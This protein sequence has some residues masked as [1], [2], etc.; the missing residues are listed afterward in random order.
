MSDENGIGNQAPVA[1]TTLDNEAISKPSTTSKPYDDDMLEAYAKE[2]E[3]ESTNGEGKTDGESESVKDAKGGQEE[4][5]K[6]K[7][8]AALSKKGDKVDDGFEKV[9]VKRV[10]NGKEV[11]FTVE[12]AIKSHVKQEDFNRN[13]DK[14]LSQADARDRKWATDQQNFKGKI[15]KLIDVAQRGDFVT[16]IRGIAKLAAGG[17]GL[18]VVKFEEKYFSQLDKVRDVLTK[19]TPA[20]QKTY[21]AERR[22]AEMEADNKALREEKEA[23]V[24]TSQLESRVIS[25][26]KHYQVPEQEF[27][28][29]YETLVKEEVGE[30]KFFKHPDDITPEEVVR[31][32]L[33]VRHEEK[34]LTA[35][36][37][38]GIE[39]D[40]ILTKIS[41]VAKTEDN[42]SVE[43]IKELIRKSGIA[44]AKTVENL[45][46]KVGK[47]PAQFQK[48][49]STKKANGIPEGYDQETMD[50]LNRHR[51]KVYKRPNR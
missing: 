14:R 8:A 46:R 6:A 43:R 11:Q 24:S 18:D 2:A 17:S 4:S 22:A 44:D 7:E 40:E 5:D 27:W 21:W 47:S 9:S 50:F 25:L 42:I 38:F 26:Q 34:V 12:E 10:I 20:E 1:E 31:Y 32:S 49:S 36:K 45:N 35:A 19:M 15:G 37:E 23:T 13:I 3:S 51:P 30:G 28:E 41:K 16:A 29:N 48:A 33:E 39:D